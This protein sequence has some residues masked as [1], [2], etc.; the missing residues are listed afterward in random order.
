MI[1]NQPKDCKR[2]IS[3][4]SCCIWSLQQFVT[5]AYIGSLIWESV[6]NKTIT[7]ADFSSQSNI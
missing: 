3:Q 1:V 5:M 4:L 6:G 2:I 7:T